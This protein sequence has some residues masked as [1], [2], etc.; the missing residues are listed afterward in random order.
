[1]FVRAVAVI[2]VRCGESA[3]C[4]RML[5]SAVHVAA[6]LSCCANSFLAGG[7]L[8]LHIYNR[9]MHSTDVSDSLHVCSLN[10]SA[11]RCYLLIGEKSINISVL[12]FLFS[13]SILS[14]TIIQTRRS[15]KNKFTCDEFCC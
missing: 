2:R 11:K 8:L 15:T 10:Q 14:I 5:L 9:L 1:M 7:V 6:Q 3:L 12:P 4:F 13:I